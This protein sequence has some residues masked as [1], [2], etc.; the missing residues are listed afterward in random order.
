MS[1]FPV[2]FQ[3][4]G[5]ILMLSLSTGPFP[6]GEWPAPCRALPDCGAPAPCGGPGFPLLPPGA[7]LPE[8]GHP[9]SSLAHTSR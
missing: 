7:H 2:S 6:G 3:G 5:E 4:D 8:E 9:A 1:V